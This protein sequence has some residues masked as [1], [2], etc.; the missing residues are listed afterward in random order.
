MKKN[1]EK[2]IL[3]VTV[4]DVEN[5]IALSSTF[6]GAGFIKEN[7]ETIAWEDLFN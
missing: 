4:C 3:D 5:V 2:P 6:Q 7:D 1:Y